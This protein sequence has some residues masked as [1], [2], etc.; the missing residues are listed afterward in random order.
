V[1]HERGAVVT[2]RAV[3]AVRRGLRPEAGDHGDVTVLAD[4]EV[5]V[6]QRRDLQPVGEAAQ[7]LLAV[8]DEAQRAD[9]AEVVVGELGEHRRV[10][11]ELGVR[12]AAGEVGR[13]THRDLPGRCSG[14]RAAARRR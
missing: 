12:P 7:P 10:G 5:L 9:A 11:G 2:V 8:E 14:A 13:L 6:G 4:V 1:E 3:L